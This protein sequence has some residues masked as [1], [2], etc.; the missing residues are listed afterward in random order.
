MYNNY[1]KRTNML[2]YDLVFSFG[3]LLSLLLFI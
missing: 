2:L 1:Q 3:L